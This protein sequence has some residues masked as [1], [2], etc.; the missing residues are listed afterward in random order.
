M[1]RSSI[2]AYINRTNT[3][4]PITVKSYKTKNFQ[5][6]RKNKMKLATLVSIAAAGRQVR[7]AQS[8]FEKMIGD[9]I[10]QIR[11]TSWLSMMLSWYLD[12]SGMV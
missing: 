5:K 12:M 1:R 11:S 4:I 6:L 2:T 8:I 9:N 7:D 10:S 3:N